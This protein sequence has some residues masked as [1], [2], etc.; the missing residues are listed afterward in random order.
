MS[1]EELQKQIDSLKKEVEN[2]KEF[3]N[4]LYNMIADDE[5]MP[6]YFGGVEVGRY[7]T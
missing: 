6:E 5:D 4:A 3:V 2:L 1:E 7:N